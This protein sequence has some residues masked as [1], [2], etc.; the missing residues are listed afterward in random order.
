MF[1]IVKLQFNLSMIF[2]HFSKFEFSFIA[3]NF[4]KL[5]FI[6]NLDNSNRSYVKLQSPPHITVFLIPWLEFSWFI[7]IDP[8]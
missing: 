5:N 8:S 7:Q 2:F 6:F 3:M 1:P 4:P